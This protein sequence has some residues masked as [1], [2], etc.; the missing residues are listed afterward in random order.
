MLQKWFQRSPFLKSI[1]VLMSG[2]TLAQIISVAALPLLQGIFSPE[3]FGVLNL[4]MSLSAIFA[5]ASTL[6]LEY[7]ILLPKSS[8]EAQT[9]V[10]VSGFFVIIFSATAILVVLTLG[11]FLMPSVNKHE[12]FIIQIALPLFILFSGFYEILNYY[13]NRIGDF[14]KMAIGKLTQNASTESYRLSSYIASFSGGSLI[15]GRV[16]GQFISSLFLLKSYMSSKPKLIINKEDLL[17]ILSQF[18]NFPLFTTPTVFI[19]LLTNYVFVYYFLEHYGKGITGIVGIANQYISLPLGIIAGSFSQVFYKKISD[20]F[21][22]KT[23]SD[24]YVRYALRLTGLGLIAIIAIYAVPE[25]WPIVLFGKKWSPLMPYIKLTVIWQSIAFVSSS[26]SFIYTRL[27]KQNIMFFFAL[28][29]LS[30]VYLSIILGKTLF[31][32]PFITM[33]LYVIGQGFY[34]STT[35]VAALFFI[36]N[37]KISE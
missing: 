33:I 36:R 15:I 11:D 35:I 32:D 3:D 1:L 27:G 21:N 17:R 19:S 6:K 13:Y 24:L 34:Y 26:L 7:A 37:S 9:I 25:N 20:V 30:L 29:Q 16:F 12:R 10:S 22:S 2:T 18:R 5:G 31:D 14:R 23:L 4:F 28:F 8:K